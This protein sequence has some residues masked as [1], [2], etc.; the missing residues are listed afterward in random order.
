MTDLVETFLSASSRESYI[1]NGIDHDVFTIGSGPSVILM[2]ELD[3]FGIPFICLAN[4]LAES[5]TVHCP[6]FFGKVG[7]KSHELRGLF[8]IR[9]EFV[10]LRLGKTGPIADW[11][12]RLAEQVSRQHCN[13]ASVGIVG[14]CMTGGLVLATISHPVIAAGVAAQPSLPLAPYGWGTKQ[15]RKD[16]GLSQDEVMAINQSRTP[17][18]A[19]RFGGDPIC[20][21][22][23]LDHLA[24]RLPQLVPPPAWL[25]GVKDHPTLTACFR[26]GTEPETKLLSERA[27]KETVS[28]LSQHLSNSFF[29]EEQH[30]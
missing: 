15:R 30:G 29:E 17:L 22:E 4:R 27:I 28:F 23:R 2:H 26:E 8:C 25:D 3:G 20:P 7:Q 6:L 13:A 9:K 24:S 19:L 14:M 21:A 1:F 11:V 18:M 10:F 12:R 16:V 5:F